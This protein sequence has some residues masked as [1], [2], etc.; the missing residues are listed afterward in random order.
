MTSGIACLVIELTL[1]QQGVMG[2]NPC[3]VE[4]LHITVQSALR[5]YGFNKPQI[6]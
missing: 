2:A 6:V 1:E 4:N 3:V 5:I